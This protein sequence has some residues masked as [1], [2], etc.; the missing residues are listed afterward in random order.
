MH[1]GSAATPT[2]HKP[3]VRPKRGPR[4][5]K[6]RHICIVCLADD[7]PQWRRC[8]TEGYQN[9]YVCNR[10]QYAA[11][12]VGRPT[13]LSSL[14]DF[15]AKTQETSAAGGG[16]ALLEG[17]DEAALSPEAPTAALPKTSAAATSLEAQ[18]INLPTLLM[19]AQ[20]TNT[21]H[22]EH[23]R[24]LE[25]KIHALQGLVAEKAATIDALQAQLS[26]G[27]GVPKVKSDFTFAASIYLLRPFANRHHSPCH[28]KPSNTV[29]LTHS[30][31]Y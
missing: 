19:A 23:V 17:I 5:T 26:M 27:H 4:K 25:M 18:V 20:A 28:Q 12:P 9:Q 24:R 7:T 22:H 10:H 30:V 29:Q 16:E 21:G 11:V 2:R 8:K 31:T 1:R 3:Q 15:A 13:D 6:G 14:S